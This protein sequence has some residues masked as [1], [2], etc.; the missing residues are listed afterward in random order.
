L[1]CST[2]MNLNP[3]MCSLLRVGQTPHTDV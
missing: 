3:V 1:P 2:V